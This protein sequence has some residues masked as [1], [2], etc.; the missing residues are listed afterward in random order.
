MHGTHDERLWRSLLRTHKKRLAEDKDPKSIHA[1]LCGFVS[2]SLPDRDAHISE[3]LDD[4]Q[5]GIFFDELPAGGGSFVLMDLNTNEIV[6][7]GWMRIPSA[8]TT[9]LHST[10][11]EPETAR[12][13][14]LISILDKIIPPG[15][16]VMIST[17]SQ[18][19]EKT[20]HNPSQGSRYLSAFKDLGSFSMFIL[21]MAFYVE[22]H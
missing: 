12:R 17:D 20:F 19:F 16:S 3:T 14:A 18:A 4:K 2:R 5:H 13:A 1:C 6:K 15:K 8:S 9:L 7:T 22:S 11:A 21:M 10:S